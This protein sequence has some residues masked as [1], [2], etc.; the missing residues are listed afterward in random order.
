MSSVERLA[1]DSADEKEPVK[2]TPA[3]LLKIKEVMQHFTKA[4]S[5]IKMYPTENP[6][7]EAALESFCKALK[8]FQEKYDDLNLGVDEFSFKYKGTVVFSDEQKKKSLPFVFFKDGMREISFL[9]GI[10]R[11]EIEQFIDLLRKDIERPPEESDIVNDIWEQEFPNIRFFAMDEYLESIG[12]GTSADIPQIDTSRLY[13]GTV[14]I[15]LTSADSLEDSE[16]NAGE[17]SE[18]TAP[19]GPS[20]VALPTL[21]EVELPQI[22]RLL[23]SDRDAPQIQELVNL[24]FEILYLEERDDQFSISLNV[25]E[26][27]HVQFIENAEFSD[28]NLLLQR[29]LELKGAVRDDSEK[30]EILLKKFL[31][32]SKK[33]SAIER[34]KRVLYEGK[35]KDYDSF[36]LYLQLLCPETISLIAELWKESKDQDFRRKISHFLDQIGRYFIDEIVLLAQKDKGS[37]KGEIIRV[38]GKI[39]SDKAVQNLKNLAE[40]DGPESRLE[41]IKALGN[42]D[43]ENVN[44]AV[45][46]FLFDKNKAVRVAASQRLRY[47]SDPSSLQKIMSIVK[48]RDFKKR[49]RIEKTALFQFLAHSKNERVYEFLCAIL[50]KKTIFNRKRNSENRLCVIAALETAGTPEAVRILKEGSSAKEKSVQRACRLALRRMDTRSPVESPALGAQNV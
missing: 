10:G 31:L 44:S 20:P 36:F 27:C 49:S 43:N 7:V 47:T 26:K 40:R 6:F 17:K 9:K 32:D 3:E 8:D 5:L 18:G 48:R 34:L 4:F 42:S 11:E 13:T 33:E 16:E 21:S 24:L 29:V 28:A 37:L 2:A 30:R 45:I 19:K 50:K 35:V 15:N 38:L 25:L 39:G 1:E 12:Q 41:I 22:E 14:T 46:D 23:S